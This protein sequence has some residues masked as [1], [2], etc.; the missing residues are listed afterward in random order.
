L[1]IRGESCL[2]L[3]PLAVPGRQR[4]PSV[5]EVAAGPAVQLFVDRVRQVQ[6]DFRLDASTALPVAEIVRQLDGIPLALELAA[7]RVRLMS[8]ASLAG[9]L[10]DRFRLLRQGDRSAQ[11]RQQTLQALIDW[12]HELLDGRERRLFRRLAVFA[13]SWTLEAAEQVCADKPAAGDEAIDA[14]DIADLLGALVEKSLISLDREQERYRMLE[15]VRQYAQLKLVAAGEDPALR[16]RHLA[17][18]LARAEGLRAELVGPGQG[19]AMASFDQ[20][21]ENLLACHAACDQAEEGAEL[22]VRLASALRRY[23][24]DRGLL[25]LGLRLAS[26][27]LLRLPASRRDAVRSNALFDIGQLCYFTGHYARAR[28]HL[29][30]LIVLARELGDRELEFDAATVLGTCL[31]GLDEAA[32]G[33]ACLERAYALAHQLG[34]PDRVAMAANCLAQVHRAR[35]HHGPATALNEETLAYARQQADGQMMGIALLNLAM[36]QVEQGRPRTAIHHL[37]E[38]A[39]LAAVQQSPILRQSLCEAAVGLAATLGD[40]ERGGRLLVQAQ[41]LAQHN[42][43]QRDPADEAYFAPRA[44]QIRRQLGEARLRALMQTLEAEAADL[45]EGDTLLFELQLW[46]DGLTPALRPAP[47]AANPLRAGVLASA[48]ESW[49]ARPSWRGMG[50]A[51]RQH[52]A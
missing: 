5:A 36:L 39:E 16:R 31:L 21:R 52:P 48:V 33:Q 22:G 1:R 27:A 2:A 28:G 49:P 8:V 11:P 6:A 7:A 50:R 26:D 23:C 35:G 29:D 14:L 18:Y 24:I 37:R 17:V 30:E 25:G 47:A 3:E 38:T 44:E 4:V 40:W 45:A 43:L 19:L 42:G 10:S 20:E 34:Q 13:G 51:T 15:T 32:A 9:R 46:L 41:A 12:S